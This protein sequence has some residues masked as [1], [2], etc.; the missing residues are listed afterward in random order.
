MLL[1]RYFTISPDSISLFGDAAK[2]LDQESFIEEEE[3]VITDAINFNRPQMKRRRVVR[4]VRE[5]QR[6]K[7]AKLQSNLMT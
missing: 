3:D 7:K 5:R 6:G 1:R 2:Y 4:G